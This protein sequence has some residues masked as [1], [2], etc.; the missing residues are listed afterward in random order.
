MA[1]LKCEM[2]GGELD[3]NADMTVGICQYCGGKNI[4]PK[5]LDKKEKL[6]TQLSQLIFP[7]KA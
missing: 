5:D 4:I 6:Y 1:V 3:L 2:C 7:N